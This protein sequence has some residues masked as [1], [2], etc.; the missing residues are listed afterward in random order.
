VLAEG[1]QGGKALGGQ[2]A[3]ELVQL[4]S[5]RRVA[6]ALLVD[7]GAGGAD[8]EADESTSRKNARPASR[9]GNPAACSGVRSA[10]AR[11]RECGPSGSRVL[12]S[13][14]TPEWSSSTARS[15]WASSL[16][17]GVQGWEGSRWRSTSA[18]TLSRTRSWSCSLLRTCR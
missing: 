7:G 6:E 4:G 16:I 9:S 18:S 10:S 3:E 11:A 17:C 8:R 2:R 14:A 12:R 1:D 13:P 15:R 5:D